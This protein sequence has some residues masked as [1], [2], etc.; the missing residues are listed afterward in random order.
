MTGLLSAGRRRGWLTT[1]ACELAGADGCEAGPA[2]AGGAGGGQAV[3]T[4]SQAPSPVGGEGP[5]PGLTIEQGEG[6][7]QGRCGECWGLPQQKK[8]RNKGSLVIVPRDP[9]TP[10]HHDC[11]GLKVQVPQNSQAEPQPPRV[12]V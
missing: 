9:D 8:G 1:R 4:G 7:A 11:C 12:M 3:P 5:S 6:V 10:S 2:E